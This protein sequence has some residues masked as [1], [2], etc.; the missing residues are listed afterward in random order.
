[1]MK[2]EHMRA[3]PDFFMNIPDPRRGQGRRHSLPTVL[4]IAVAAHFADLAATKTFRLGQTAWGKRHASTFV[5]AGKM[6]N[7]LFP[8]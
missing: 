6:G 1:M 7:G 3:L 8:A 2:A 5:A 4:A